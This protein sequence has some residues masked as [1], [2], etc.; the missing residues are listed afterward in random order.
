MMPENV[1]V[2]MKTGTIEDLQ[3]KTE[4]QP[5]VPLDEGS[6]Y[7]AVD[8]ENHIGQIVY[9]APDG[10]GGVD[11][12]VMST[13][14]EHTDT[15]DS[16]RLAETASQANSLSTSRIIDGIEFNG[17]EDVI[18]FGTCST[19]ADTVIKDVSCSDFVL[20]PGSRI[21][22][23]YL[24]TNTAENPQLNVNNTGAKPIYYRGS[25]IQSNFLSENSTHEYVYDGTNWNYVGS[26]VN[27]ED[28]P[29]IYVDDETE[30][31]FITTGFSI[32]N[33]DEVGY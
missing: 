22:V 6:V 8:T 23:K 29:I 12:I 25:V 17:S 2:K 7:F 28:I 14:G 26:L 11:R 21:T 15:A 16:A 27:N 20:I 32:Q 31:L 5:N 9:D 18:H 4:D 10:A 3:S 30:T 24:V 1:L 33:G 13:Y 19:T